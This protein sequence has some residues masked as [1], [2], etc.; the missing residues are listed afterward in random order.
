M[1]LAALSAVVLWAGATLLLSRVRWFVRPSLSE[2]LR[3]YSLGAPS[4]PEH[5]KGLSLAAVRD[6]AGPFARTAGGR[7]A[8][9]FGIDEDLAT[10]LERVHAAI[11][12]TMF[13]LR[14]L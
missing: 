9:A 4:T 11:D 8:V 3:P 14:Q 13:R 7:V 6:I 10:R 5:A 1:R 12:P 2:R